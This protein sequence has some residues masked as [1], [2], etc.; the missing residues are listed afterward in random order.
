MTTRVNKFEAD[1]LYQSRE[2]A[3]S[4]VADLFPRLRVGLEIARA[5]GGERSIMARVPED[6][7]PYAP[8][9]ID[10]ALEELGIGRIAVGKPEE[11]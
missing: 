10:Y 3:R 1:A 8:E 4:L 9:D 11:L 2:E 5:D 6:T 7:S